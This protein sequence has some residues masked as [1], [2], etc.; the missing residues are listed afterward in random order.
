MI[1]DVNQIKFSVRTISQDSNTKNQIFFC[2][3]TAHYQKIMA[4]SEIPMLVKGSS[5]LFSLY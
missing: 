2:L 4:H 1:H 3:K 5:F